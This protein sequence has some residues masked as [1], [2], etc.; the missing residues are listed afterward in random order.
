M[1][2]PP[3]V[4][5]RAL[6]DPVW[7]VLAAAMAA[8][9]L[10]VA[11]IGGLVAPLT[12]RRRAMRLALF[13]AL[14]LLLD[15]TLLIC[16]AALWLRYPLPG[17]RDQ[18]RWSKAHQGL[19]RRAL[20]LLV[21]TARPLFGF[22]VEVQEPPGSSQITGKPLLVV[23]R[24]GGPGDSF[25]LVEIL[26]SR[27]GRRPLIVLKETLRWDPGLDVL[28]GRMPSCFVR[29]G[30]G[31]KVASRLT[32]LA[33]AMAADDAILLFPEGGNWTPHR[34]RRAIARLRLAGRRQA[35]ADAAGNPNVL[36]PQPTGLLACLQ[37][38]P[39]LDVAV[40]AHTGLEDLVGPAEVWRALPLR[41]RPMVVRWWHEPAAR[42]PGSEEGRREWL[43]LQWAIV[44]AWIDARKAARDAGGQVLDDAALDG[45]VLDEA[46][47]DAALDHA[48]LDE[49]VLDEAAIDAALD[50]AAL[51]EA[52]PDHAAIDA[53]LDDAAIPP[54]PEPLAGPVE[55]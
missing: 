5:R 7:P 35:A 27:Y 32:D 20:G 9:F 4:V 40:V 21:A 51:D 28:L 55:L 46:A 18:A 13:A 22:A 25:A 31:A 45:A 17:R 52:A 54:V 30:D 1:R 43:R 49:A 26:L 47:I 38:R 12:R 14:Y 44:D 15:A 24:H 53:A 33:A 39:G 10:L 29:K 23:S 16:C 48:A 2:P 3:T 8:M 41:D 36:P 11:A 6:L 37:G 34:H 42:L 50:H 19:L